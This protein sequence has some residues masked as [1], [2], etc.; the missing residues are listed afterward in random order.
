VRWYHKYVWDR[1]IGIGVLTQQLKNDL[2]AIG[3]REDKVIVLPDGVDVDTFAVHL[4]KEAARSA[5]QLPKDRYMVVY[6]GSFFRHDWKG[7]DVL[8]TAADSMRKYTDIY[9]VLVG[10]TSE[11]YNVLSRQ[12][13]PNCTFVTTVPHEQIPVFLAAADVLVLP[14]KDDGHVSSYYTSPMKLF[15]YMAAGRPIVASRISSIEEILT[16]D[17]VQFVSPN[18]GDALARGILSI[19]QDTTY[20]ATIAAR[21]RQKVTS[22]TWLTRATSF[23]N[24]YKKMVCQNKKNV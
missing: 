8:I 22:Y 23:I 9:F 17:E 15:E 3:I 5:L 21:A 11:E 13:H 16:A 19:L 12:D 20:A 2:V 1:T 18:N 10:A 6:T 7:V 24:F 4:S 14:N